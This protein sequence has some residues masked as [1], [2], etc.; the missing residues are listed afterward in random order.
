MSQTAFSVRV[1]SIEWL[2]PAVH[3]L[4]LQSLDGTHLPA[5]SAGAHIDLRLG[6]Q[7]ARSYSVVGNAGD[8]SRYEIAVAK[9]A[10]SR[11]GSRH[12]HEVLR[13]GD[14]LQISAPRNHFAL[15][16]DAPESVLIAGGIGIT[17]LWAM[18][19][20]LQA[21]GRP[22]QLFY[23]ARSRQHAAYL[24]EIEA[25]AA[26]STSGRLLTHFDDEQG[27]VPPDVAG[28]VNNA[29]QQAHLYCCG[30]QPM[31]DAFER[32]TAHREP[33]HVHLERFAPAQDQ[34]SA[35]AF[36]LRLSRAGRE[37]AVPADKSILEVLLENGIDAQYGCMQGACG[38]CEAAVVD[39]IPDHRDTV[40]SNETKAGN[41]TMLIC[42]SRS[43]TPSLTLD[44]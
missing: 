12:V 44:L 18:V 39:G 35:A 19:Q 23:A 24:P 22:W 27:G 28:V 41:R 7:L 31:L 11:G 6:P 10:R 32:A 16:E 1:R 34:A 3:R 36:R 20:R 43:Q 30:P 9:D 26:R 40:L 5:A 13:V 15:I 4:Q 37:F 38:L 29:P 33:S 17:P 2:T 8:P 25:L 14:V 21:L 42:C